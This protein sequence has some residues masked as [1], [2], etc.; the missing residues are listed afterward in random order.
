MGD[1]RFE[2]AYARLRGASDPE[3]VLRQLTD[4]E[5]V[6][7]LAAA[8]RES[9]PLL[10]NVL[11]TAALN[12]MSRLRAALT[13]LGEG[14][15]A[16]GPRGEVQWSNPAADQILGWE[17]GKAMGKPFED[18]V[19]HLD[20]HGNPVP[21]ESCRM[22]RTILSGEVAHADGDHF[23]ARGGPRVCVEYT[24]APILAPDGERAGMVLAFRECGDRKEAEHELRLS[25]E[26]YKSLFDNLPEPIISVAL[27]ATIIDANA[28]A[29]ALIDVPIEESRGRSF[30][31]FV[32]PEDTQSA[33]RL[34]ERVLQGGHER[35]RMRIRHKRGHYIAVDAIGVAVVVDG[36][37]VGVHGIVRVPR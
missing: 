2:H 25:R 20:A 23:R 3:R 11:A 32:H 21:I 27:D 10:A 17:P 24:C 26:R 5:V 31:E 16:L 6:Q 37:V 36:E 33:L 7:A 30:A 13:Y 8:S 9:D 19:E 29:E 18:T 22:M 34:F 35:M 15:V 4:D 28:A 12:R 1:R 14:I